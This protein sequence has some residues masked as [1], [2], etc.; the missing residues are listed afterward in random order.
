[1]VRM[2][3]KLNPPAWEALLTDKGIFYRYCL[4]AGL[5]V[6]KLLG[7]YRRGST[8]W[9]FPASV[10]ANRNEWLS[11]FRDECPPE[12][13]VKPTTGHH[14]SSFRIVKRDGEAFHILPG[15]T[16]TPRDFLAS[17][18][19]DPLYRE[20]VIQERLKDHPVLGEIS[21]PEALTTARV[22]SLV[23]RSGEVEIIVVDFKLI[24]GE[25]TTSNFSSGMSGNLVSQ[26]SVERGTLEKVFT[27][28]DGTGYV[29]VEKHPQSG[30]HLAGFQLPFWGE[31]RE[32]VRTAA[33]KFLP[34]RAVG[35]DVIFTADG[36]MLL[37]GNFWFDAPNNSLKAES[38]FRHLAEES[39]T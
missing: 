39:R 32:L 25:N 31:V 33:L 7:I 22:T 20:F 30:R 10:I 13:V 23:T 34:I 5:P 35:W 15:E 8:G 3:R 21:S 6:P 12:L 28:V 36:P 14:G 4:A 1:M 18:D 27:V 2:Q 38:I 26:V 17:L 11:F 37:E 29:E 24:L 9:T 19:S 16:V